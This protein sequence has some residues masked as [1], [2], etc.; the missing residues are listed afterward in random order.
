MKARLLTITAISLLG[1][2]SC[3]KDNVGQD[4][5]FTFQLKATN[6][7]STVARTMA[8]VTWQS[9]F[10][11][12][13]LIKFEAKQTGNEVEF[14]STVQR[15]IDLFALPTDIGNISIPA[16]TY[17]ETEFKIF[18]APNSGEAAFQLQG[19]IDNTPV[20]FKV[21]NSNLIK[22]E[23]HQ[24]TLSGSNIAL[25]TIDLSGLT[26]GL[27]AI[28]FTSATQTNGTIVISSSSN[29]N[30][31]NAILNNLSRVGETEVEIHH[32]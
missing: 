28:D 20:V 23:Q 13:N 29:A 32:H 8:T 18:I 4:S 25:T 15:H 9:G 2:S 11:N 6:P 7:T 30:L 14:K 31:Y 17:D 3:K 22:A 12:A 10:V 16:G 5:G 24:V 26:Q 27:S 21:D 19:T 1:L